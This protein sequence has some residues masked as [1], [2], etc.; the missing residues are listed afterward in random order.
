MTLEELTNYAK[1]FLEKNYD[2]PLNIPIQRNNRLRSS[3]GRF[4]YNQDANPLRIE[5][6]G[7][8][9]DYASDD[10]IYN[11]LRH[12]CIHYALFVLGKAY[13]DGADDFEAALIA[14][15]AAASNTL[16]IGKFY[17]YHC[18]ICQQVYET[19]VK[20]VAKTPHKYR[21][22]CCHGK[23]KVMGEKIYRSR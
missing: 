2:L 6:A 1:D 15:D 8:M 16:K 14:H 5:I 12:E 18:M 20:Q 13:Q 19:R 10:I 17:S 23:V 21:S 22:N 9:F 11:V 4:V 7:L 3:Y